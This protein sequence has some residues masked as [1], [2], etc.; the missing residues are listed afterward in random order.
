M[1]EKELGQRIT[2]AQRAIAMAAIEAGSTRVTDVAKAAGISRE[3][4]RR[5]LK[6]AG[7]Y[8]RPGN[9]RPPRVEEIPGED[10]SA[11]EVQAYLDAHGSFR[12][13]RPGE[14]EGVHVITVDPERI[15]RGW[16][17]TPAQ[18]ALLQQ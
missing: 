6:E 9:K 18:R 1:D 7:K 2:D 4:A 3:A 13:I 14:D 8:E 5:I 15:A 17:L 16:E 10:A 11:E 12:R